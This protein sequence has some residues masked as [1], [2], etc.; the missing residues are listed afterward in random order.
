M[1]A[2]YGRPQPHRP[3][4]GIT[5]RAIVVS[6]LPGSR[7][8]RALLGFLIVALVSLA[9]A[10]A[11][12]ADDVP[13]LDGQ[14]TDLSRDRVLASGRS[15]I[16]PVL[17]EL[18][19]SDDIQLF[20]LFVE[21]TG[22]RTVTDFTDETARSN[23]LGGNDALLVVA[24]A[25]RT[26]A[27]W[28]SDSYL[29]RLTDRELLA[30]LSQ[31][32]EPRLR[33]ADFAGAVVAAADGVRAASRESVPSE[34]STPSGVPGL[35]FLVPAVIAGTGGVLLWSVLAARRRDR[36]AAVTRA[37][38]DARR[39]QEANALLIRADESLRDAQEEMAY[40]EA[41]FTAADVAPYRE[42]V[43]SASIELKAA[44]TIR[45]QLDDAVP[46]DADTRR[47]LVDE[48]ATRA[49]KALSLLEEQRR[50]VE[51][52]RDLERRAPQLLAE[53]PER[54][55]AESARLPDAERTLTSL[56][57]Y[58]E[59]SWSSVKG[60]VADG[61]ELLARATSAV[62]DGAT[63]LK[64]TNAASA[65]KAVR[66]A[67]QDLTE[68][69]R[70]LD[71]VGALARTIRE[72]EQ[73]APQHLTAAATDVEKARVALESGGTPDHQRR[74]AD[75]R[76]A[77]AAAQSEIS[78]ATPDFLAAIT[79]AAKADTGADEI[80]AEV[81]QEEERRVREA[82]LLATQLQLARGS[83][84]RASDYIAPRRRTIGS[85]ARTRLAEAERHLERAQQL[86]D[87]GDHAS[88]VAEAQRARQLADDAWSL[89]QDDMREA[90]SRGPWTGFP[91]GGPVIIPF[92]F[93]SGGGGWRPSGGGLPGLP[94]PGGRSVGGRW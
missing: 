39:T 24:L 58:A 5:V 26:D 61:R 81:R 80:L 32:V 49:T 84:Q 63:A 13:R 35:G 8:A 76:S 56:S 64:E 59:R 28:R 18:I 22:G 23:S 74:L 14:I 78:S 38:R 83:Y 42:A 57:R 45:Q 30:V 48:I 19:R 88:A 52:M 25:D 4:R 40:A 3:Q 79:L 85:G 66:S 72:A 55:A 20:V 90:D 9:F 77:L 69:A 21:S 65:A 12:F 87:A 47:R 62:A 68:A 67:Q 43:A 89:A 82:R 27:L 7:V 91:R 41:Q 16:Q 53:L 34:P 50:R 37:Q 46:E 17:D 51:E 86:V 92:P 36:M 6:A 15:R 1:D 75:A 33:D 44:F 10:S 54:I 71:A 73:T 11:A 29:D 93:P 60:N 2:G 70:L 31:Q 94:R